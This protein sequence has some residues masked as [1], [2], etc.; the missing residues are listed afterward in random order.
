MLQ[1]SNVARPI[2]IGCVL[3]AS[4][5]SVWGQCRMQKL[6]GSEAQV[7]DA[8]GSSIAMDRGLMAVGAGADDGAAADT[9]VVYVYRSQSSNWEEDVILYASDGSGGEVFGIS[10]D[11]CDN[12]LS[13]GAGMDSDNGT[14]AGAAYLF[15]FDPKSSAWLE[16]KLVSSDIAAYDCF[17]Y[18]ASISGDTLIAGSGGDDDNGLRSGS[19]YIYRYDG[20]RWIEEKKL[21]ASDGE[22][23][24]LFG[25][26]VAI[27]NG[28]VARCRCGN[29]GTANRSPGRAD[30]SAARGLQKSLV[31]QVQRVLSASRASGPVRRSVE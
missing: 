26:A 6:L 10:V 27:D 9:G 14:Y 2:V 25:L 20:Q 24:D 21:L 29:Q 17:G 8:F 11:I 12:R 3:S 23:E 16:T 19:A 31:L 22:A 13:I 7:H 1:L 15:Q 5:G 30:R 4:S 28:G 18:S